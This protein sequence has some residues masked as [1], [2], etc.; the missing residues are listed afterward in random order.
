M[1]KF[2]F[3]FLLPKLFFSEILRKV[4]SIMFILASLVTYCLNKLKK[5]KFNLYNL[6]NIIFKS[7][8]TENLLRNLV[9]LNCDLQYKPRNFFQLKEGKQKKLKSY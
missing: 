3:P 9:F 6:M 4:I 8:S 7:E 2:N 1:E 5:Q